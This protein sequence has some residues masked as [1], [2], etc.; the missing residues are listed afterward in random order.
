[1]ANPNKTL[2][3]QRLDEYVNLTGIRAAQ[4]PR[5]SGW[6]ELGLPDLRGFTPHLRQIKLFKNQKR[7]H[8]NWLAHDLLHILFYDFVALHLGTQS[9]HER[10]R[11]F[12]NHL[13]SEA[14]AVLALDYHI[15]AFAKDDE[16]LTVDLKASDWK[17]FK[18]SNPFLPE[19]NSRAFCELLVH[20]YLT[21]DYKTFEP[22]SQMSEK[23][24]S[25]IGHEI[26][27]A[28]KQ[29]RYV[30]MWW[31]DLTNEPPS[32]LAVQIEGS[33]V[34]E[35]V[36]E[37]TDLLLYADNQTWKNYVSDVKAALQDPNVF[38]QFPKYKKPPAKLDFRFTDIEALT[39]KVLGEALEEAKAPSASALFLC[40]QLVALTEP[41][42]DE[43]QTLAEIRSIAQASQSN[44]ITSDQWEFLR[45][46][47][48]TNLS[49][50]NGDVRS[51]YLSTFLLP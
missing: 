3:W 7:S 1:M 48:R 23:Y 41:T 11:F 32:P 47:A 19:P 40:W 50:L 14:F 44:S 2:L 18:L 30:A 39:P 12:E 4:T 27:Y 43:P 17:E 51:E 33:A 49:K 20:H 31:D 16:T 15:L 35:P 13:A 5:K 42:G 37:L 29:R 8:D 28:S 21:G 38:C 10:E 36:W 6:T 34:A 9:W 22:K 25:W 46:L 26:R 24:T 45:N